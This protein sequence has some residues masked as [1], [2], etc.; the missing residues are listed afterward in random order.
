MF[1]AVRLN[2]DLAEASSASM[3]G[4][5]LTASALGLEIGINNEAHLVPARR[6]N[7]HTGK[8]WVEASLIVGYGGLVKLSGS[9]RWPVG[10][11]PAGWAR[12]TSS[13]SPT[14]RAAT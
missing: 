12:M 6:T 10:S 5:I 14:A 7:K 8:Q 9:T 11:R 2:T 1:N 13:T 3:I 4:A